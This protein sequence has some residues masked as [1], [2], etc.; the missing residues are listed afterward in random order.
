MCR[1]IPIQANSRDKGTKT[2]KSFGISEPGLEGSE[3]DTDHQAHIIKS[4]CGTQ[5]STDLALLLA[6]GTT[7]QC[8]LF[9]KKSLEA[10]RRKR[11]QG[12]ILNHRAMVRQGRG[13][14]IKWI[15]KEEPSGDL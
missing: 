9:R 11:L 6:R 13:K 12:A 7:G 2:S 14:M 3:R 5:Q 10:E 8:F 4:L 1:R 15:G